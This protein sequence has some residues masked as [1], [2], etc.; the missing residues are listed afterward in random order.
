MSIRSKFLIVLFRST[1]TMLILSLLDL[2]ITEKGMLKFSV[3]IVDTS[4]SY[5]SITSA[6]YTLMLHCLVH[7]VKEFYLSLFLSL[8]FFFFGLFRAEPSAYMEVPRLGIESEL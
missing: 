1:V 7:H 5:S 4:S 8:F 6:S 3:I 2:S